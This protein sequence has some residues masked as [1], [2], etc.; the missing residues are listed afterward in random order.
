MSTGKNFVPYTHSVPGELQSGA[1][2]GVSMPMTQAAT[3]VQAGTPFAVHH[4][5]L[6]GI[7]GGQL[8]SPT[9]LPHN[10]PAH[11]FVAMGKARL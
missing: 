6:A 10:S 3:P 4:S 7:S 8:P 9:G 11:Q 2:N 5:P 1:P